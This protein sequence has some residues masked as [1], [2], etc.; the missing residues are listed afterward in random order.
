MCACT[1][2]WSPSE[3]LFF[4]LVEQ[5]VSHPSADHA[6]HRDGRHER[7]RHRRDRNPATLHVHV[8][9]RRLKELL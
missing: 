7:N 3:T 5:Q 8:L 9:V 2:E 4:V 1:N 6:D